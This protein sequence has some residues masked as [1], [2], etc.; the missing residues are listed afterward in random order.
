[1][2]KGKK[3]VEQ[4]Y[5]YSY[6]VGDNLLSSLSVYN[7]GYQ[8]CG[9]DQQW[10]PG[11]RDHYCIHHIISGKGTYVADKKI[12]HLGEGDSFILY[13][14]TEVKYYAD[15]DDPWEYAW[16]GF[17]GTDAAVMVRATDFARKRP[18]IGR[19]KIPGDLIWRQLEQIYQVRGTTY[20]AAAAM[21][22][23]LYTMLSVFIH[24]AE[25][26]EKKDDLRQVYVE[27]AKDYI[28]SSYSYPITVEDVADYTG[29][30]RSYL[31]RAF[32]AYQKQSPKEYLTEYRIR[33]ACHLLRETGLSV[34]S[35]AYSVGFEDNLYFSKAFKKK[36]QMS[37]SQYRKHHMP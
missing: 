2:G 36:M 27:R 12:Y 8:Q 9:P 26:E 35:I 22:G 17:M 14:D 3:S 5:K 34:A 32:Q 28:A 23:A 11:I 4:T 16:A 33:Q 1:M 20:E 37:P 10:G 25:K 19:D 15:P 6:K 7:V 30:S 21:T 24:Y 29:I 13:P 18:V 31:F